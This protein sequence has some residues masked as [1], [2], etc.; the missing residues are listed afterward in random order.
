[1][2]LTIA[3]PRNS[4][5]GIQ[6]QLVANRGEIACRILRTLPLWL[7]YRSGPLSTPAAD[8]ATPLQVG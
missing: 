8:A 3:T 2:G 6:L 1:L 7:G 5:S 4:H